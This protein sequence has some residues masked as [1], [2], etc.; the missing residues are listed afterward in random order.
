[1]KRQNNFSFVGVAPILAIWF[2]LATAAAARAEK[3]FIQATPEEVERLAEWHREAK[4][5]MLQNNPRR[6][7]RIYENILLEEPDDEAAYTQMGNA[8]SLV[9]DFDRAKDA[10]FN[11]L[12][13]N[14]ENEAAL[15]GARKIMNPDE[16]LYP[17]IS[18]YQ[19]PQSA[20]EDRK[21]NGD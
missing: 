13:I 7:I 20:A 18:P 11:A 3:N 17:E 19:P 6:A 8:Y 2:F 12:H 5:S 15:Y 14:P 4:E 16:S 10:Y 21:G 9:G 1:M